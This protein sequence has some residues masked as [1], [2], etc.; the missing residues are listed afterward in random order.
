MGMIVLVGG[1]KGGVG[2]ST[3]AT[4]LAAHLAVEGVDVLLLDADPQAT[5][6][7]WVDRRTA[8]G[9][10]VPK[11]GIAQ[12]LGDVRPS[13]QDYA[14]RYA[15][16]IIDAGGRDSKEMRSAMVA[17]H[18]M[19]IPLRPSVP[20]LETLYHMRDLLENTWVYNPDLKAVALINMASSNQM[21]REAVN[22]E[23]T[24]LKRHDWLP[25]SENRISDRKQFRDAFTIGL[26]V[27]EMDSSAACAEIQLLA[28]EIFG[29]D[30]SLV[31]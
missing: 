10:E 15:V 20:D 5:T 9:F 24:L 12:K 31:K 4:N 21:N 26:G 8:S 2:K 3:I 16:V 30:L 18:K 27:V 23:A 6:T 7:N 19:Y 29:P 1:E 14:T 25:L 11:I 22:S 13:A 28:E 17:A